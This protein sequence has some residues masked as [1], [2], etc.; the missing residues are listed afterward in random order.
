MANDDAINAAINGGIS[1][2]P[3]T[4]NEELTEEEFFGLDVLDSPPLQI[5]DELQYLH[6]QD[7]HD[8][9][10]QSTPSSS[11]DLNW[12]ENLILTVGEPVTFN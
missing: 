1:I 9:Q 8:I 3:S 6:E 4:F 5:D 10:F 12:E 11:N 7:L 2:D